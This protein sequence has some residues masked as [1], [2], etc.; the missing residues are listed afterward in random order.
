MKEIFA[1]MAGYNQWANAR[2]YKTACA[3]T[4]EQYR[5]N[6]GA[7]F[8]SMHGTLNHLLVADRVWM[9]RFTGEGPQ[10]RSLDEILFD[11]LADLTRARQAEDTRII[12]YVD[13]LTEESLA[14][15]FT[16]RTM[17]APQD[18]TQPLAP[19]LMHVFN[20]QTHHRGQAH[21]LLTE[22][23]GDAPS[24]DLILYQRGSGLGMN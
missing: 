11:E 17:T 9:R 4:R 10:P 13:G 24:F 8:G 5:T 3:L 14:A 6:R 2:L 7:F 12:D 22:I 20:H 21:C 16:Y 23:T 1:M 19:A 15:R 18:I